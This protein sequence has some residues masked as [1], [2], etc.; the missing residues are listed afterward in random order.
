M[1]RILLVRLEDLQEQ[2]EK[3]APASAKTADD[4]A[5]SLL[6]YICF[7]TLSVYAQIEDHLND[8]EFRRLT[9]DMMLAWEA[10]GSTNKN[11]AK[12]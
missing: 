7:R 4:Y 9:Y 6:E 3:D 5:R 11:V 12:V 8:K 10:P 1:G 2:F